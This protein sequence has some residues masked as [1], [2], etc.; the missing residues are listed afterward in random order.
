MVTFRAKNQ[1]N[2]DF[3]SEATFYI[4][5]KPI[6]GNT[7]KTSVADAYKVYAKVGDK[8]SNVLTLQATP[9]PASLRLPSTQ[10]KHPRRWGTKSKVHGTGC[11]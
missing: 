4:N 9:R 3:T 5:D 10:E 7:F 1:A 11:Q 8:Q 6:S 2:K